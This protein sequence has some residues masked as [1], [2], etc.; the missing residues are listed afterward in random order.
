VPPGLGNVGTR[1]SW[2]EPVGVP[3]N[4]GAQPQAPRMPAILHYPMQGGLVKN[5]SGTY[6]RASAGGNAPVSGQPR[7]TA[8]FGGDRKSAAPHLSTPLSMHTSG[9]LPVSRLSQSGLRVAATGPGHLSPQRVTSPRYM[10]SSLE[11]EGV[12]SLGGAP[13]PD[14]PSTPSMPGAQ[15]S[16]Q[17]PWEEEQQV[18]EAAQ[19]QATP[20]R[21]S[22]VVDGML[23]HGSQ[24]LPR[25]AVPGDDRVLAPAGALQHPHQEHQ[26]RQPALGVA[27]V[28]EPNAGV[29]ALQGGEDR[30]SRKSLRKVISAPSKRNPGGLEQ[31]LPALAPYTPPAAQTPQSGRPPLQAQGSERASPRHVDRVTRQP[32][33]VILTPDPSQPDAPGHS[34]AA[35]NGREDGEGQADKQHTTN[36]LAGQ[37][38]AGGHHT[39]KTA[40]FVLLESDNSMTSPMKT[41][42]LLAGLHDKLRSMQVRERQRRRS[43][44]HPC[45]VA[46]HF[47]GCS[48]AQRS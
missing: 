2:G 39:R 6:D 35:A 5:R 29:A 20:Q 17:R 25:A 15:R 32:P 22:L 40:S 37:G 31:G 44:Q 28:A 43:T 10:I 4:G 8:S 30:S 45:V 21:I 9:E 18:Q 1:V 34:T 3:A 12:I 48:H 14:P 13:I 27:A 47:H 46:G 11:G 16:Q 36:A 23:E 33:P 42:A 41:N 7:H 24:Q 26:T 19:Q 38:G